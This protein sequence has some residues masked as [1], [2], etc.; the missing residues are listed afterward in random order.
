M[1]RFAV[2]TMRRSN[3]CRAGWSFSTGARGGVPV[4]S[5]ITLVPR[6]R[7]RGNSFSTPPPSQRRRCL[8]PR[9]ARLKRLPSRS[10]RRSTRTQSSLVGRRGRADRRRCAAVWPPEQGDVAFVSAAP[11]EQWSPRRPSRYSTMVRPRCARRTPSK[12]FS[13]SAPPGRCAAPDVPTRRPAVDTRPGSWLTLHREPARRD[14]NRGRRGA[15]RTSEAPAHG[16]GVHRHVA[17]YRT[18][19]TTTR[20]WSR[21]RRPSPRTVF[22]EPLPRRATGVCRGSPRSS[23]CRQRRPAESR[24]WP[25]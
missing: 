5:L 19:E 8:V 23:R 20:S 21:P 4:G 6:P 24:H 18:R 9:P 1:H 10:T 22:G 7:T 12:R 14:D 11:F 3:A 16:H 2:I 13:V 17:G 15:A 25:A